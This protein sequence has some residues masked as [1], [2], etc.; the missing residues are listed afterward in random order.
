MKAFVDLFTTDYGLFSIIVI[1]GVILMGFWFFRFF[2]RKME[3]S[4]QENRRLDP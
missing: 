4:E 3:E 2:I 1:V